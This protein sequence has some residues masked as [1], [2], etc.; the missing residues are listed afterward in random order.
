MTCIIWTTATVWTSA[1]SWRPVDKRGNADTDEICGPTVGH[2]LPS[3]E[4]SGRRRR[5]PPQV[6][7]TDTPCATRSRVLQPVTVTRNGRVKCERIKKWKIIFLIFLLLS[8]SFSLLILLFSRS[9]SYKDWVLYIYI[10]T[11][12][13][14][15]NDA[16]LL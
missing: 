10:F 11:L 8:S 7:C 4:S 16:R 15:P 12:W 2:L 9:L 5:R 1:S 13:T 6:V 3:V 14:M